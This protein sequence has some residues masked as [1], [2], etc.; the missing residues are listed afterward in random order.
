MSVHFPDEATLKACL[1][2]KQFL[3]TDDYLIEKKVI[4]AAANKF[5]NQRKNSLGIEMELNFML[6]DLRYGGDRDAIQ[7]T[8][9]NVSR[10]L[11]SC[12]K[13]Q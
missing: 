8:V 10:A 13:K 7:T 1:E 6:R 9:M 3:Q 4:D 11:E 2:V 5:A 12:A